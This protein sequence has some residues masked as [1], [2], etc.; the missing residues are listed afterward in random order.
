[1]SRVLDHL[2]RAAPIGLTEVV[3]A[4]LWYFPTVLLGFLAPRQQLGWF[5]AS[6]RVVMARHTFVWLYFFNMLP[7][8]SR[9]VLEPKSSVWK[10]VSGSLHITAGVCVLG[11]LVVT[12]LS[13]PIASLIYGGSFSGAGQSLAVLIWLLPLSMFSGHFRYTLLAYDLQT[14]LLAITLVSAFVTIVL[15]FLLIPLAGATGAAAAL[16]AGNMVTLILGSRTVRARIV[17]IGVRDSL[18]LP[19][20]GAAMF[21]ATFLALARV[22][23][24]LARLAAAAGY[25]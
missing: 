8:I 24:S 16:V 9:C 10:L 17:E 18:G 15:C 4:S 1:M 21:I 5:T 6:H 25:P 7:S 3:W 19:L 12:V 23:V 2:R 11:G 22:N 20:A 13:R 14:Q